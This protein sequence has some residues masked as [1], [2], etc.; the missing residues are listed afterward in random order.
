MKEGVKRTV[1]VLDYDD[2]DDRDFPDYGNI[3]AAYWFDTLKHLTEEELDL[4]NEN[5]DRYIIDGDIIDDLM[6]SI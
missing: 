2:G 3:A 6:G 4:V 5:M 1:I